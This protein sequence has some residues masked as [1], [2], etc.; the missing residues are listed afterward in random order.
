MRRREAKLAMASVASIVFFLQGGCRRHGGTHGAER[1][2]D[3]AMPKRTTSH[4]R[5][6]G[7][8]KRAGDVTA[9]R[10]SLR[11]GESDRS[12][13]L[14]LPAEYAPERAYPLVLG[15]HGSGADGAAIRS[16]LALE[17]EAKGAAI[18]AYP[19]G[20]D[21]GEGTGWH[22]KQDGRDVA[23]VDAMLEELEQRYCLDPAAIFAVG[24]S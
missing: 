20:L 15:F 14:A 18:F 11:V 10:V 8:G 13:Y 21:V 22:L 3:A 23:F 9:H 24:F 6:P 5:T 17:E 19:D 12:Y 2:A 4:A 16:H 1:A 7:C